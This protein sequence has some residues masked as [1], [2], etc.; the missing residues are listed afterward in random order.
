ML[1]SRKPI[2]NVQ[3]DCVLPGWIPGSTRCEAIRASP[4]CCAELACRL[5][6]FPSYDFFGR[7]CDLSFVL[8]SDF[9]SLLR[10]RHSKTSST[11]A[12]LCHSSLQCG[13]NTRT[14]T[15]VTARMV[16]MSCMCSVQ[17]TGNSEVI[18]Y[19]ILRRRRYSAP[20]QAGGARCSVRQMLWFRFCC[21]WERRG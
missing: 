10:S 14:R 21:G 13:R 20:S 4:T 9:S 3:I 7:R 12:L 5:S 8:N 18:H 2:S 16:G 19:R 11:H 1:G 6:V 15:G 17:I